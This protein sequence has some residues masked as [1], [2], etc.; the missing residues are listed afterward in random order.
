MTEPTIASDILGVIALGVA[1]YAA[2]VVFLV[3]HLLTRS[4]R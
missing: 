2:Y 3:V 1:V 4:R